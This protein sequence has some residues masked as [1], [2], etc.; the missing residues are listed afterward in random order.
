MTSAAR[1]WSA[2]GWDDWVTDETVDEL[3]H[4]PP[5]LAARPSSAELAIVDWIGGEPR[6]D[7]EH[8]S[9]NRPKRG[10]HRE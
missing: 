10:I 5:V 9:S 6:P 7:Q 4:R 2:G 8:K 3:G 1:T